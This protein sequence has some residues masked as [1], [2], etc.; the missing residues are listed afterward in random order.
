MMNLPKHA[1]PVER[2]II[3]ALVSKVLDADQLITVYDGTETVLKRSNQ[4]QAILESMSHAGEDILV[5]YTLD[6]ERVGS[7][8]LVYGNEPEYVI[9]DYSHPAGTSSDYM[10]NLIESVTPGEAA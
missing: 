7:V 8:Y 5:I 6:G 3:Q 9:C 4:P 1:H 10:D 2:Q